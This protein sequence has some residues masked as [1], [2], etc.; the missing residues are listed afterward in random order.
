MRN[1]CFPWGIE[2][3]LDMDWGS[4]P[5]SKGDRNFMANLPC[6]R[7]QNL[8]I[9]THCRFIRVLVMQNW[10][11]EWKM[12]KYHGVLKRTMIGVTNKRT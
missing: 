2:E 8:A 12:F 9:G 1:V 11:N 5:R 7:E 3:I 4:K 6:S 10:R